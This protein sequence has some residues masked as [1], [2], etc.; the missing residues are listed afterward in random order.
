MRGIFLGNGDRAAVDVGI[1]AAAFKGGDVEVSVDEHIS[2]FENGV[3]VVAVGRA[4]RGP[5]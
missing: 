1:D 4:L 5:W 3:F 2:L